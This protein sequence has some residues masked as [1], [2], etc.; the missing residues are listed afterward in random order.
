MA[1]GDEPDAWP[2][3]NVPDYDAFVAGFR[4]EDVAALLSG[5]LATGLNLCVECCDRHVEGDRVA[6]YWEG[7]EGDST[8]HTFAELKDGAARFA[9]VLE[10]HGVGPGDRVAVMLPRIPELMVAAL[11]IWRMGAV[12]VPLFTA[13]GAKAIEYRLERSAARLIVTDGA[14]RAKLDGFAKLPPVMVVTRAPDEAVAAGALHFHDEL[15]AEAPDFAPVPRHADDPFLLMFTSGTV[16]SPK[17]VAVPYKALLS[18]IVYLKYGIGLRPE[19]RFWNMADP[20][21]A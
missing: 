17:G 8:V 13:F 12:Y 9:K 1:S 7:A 2:T 14:N 15:A 16:G 18:F 4:P 3:A 10:T 5:D 20:G 19:D 6:L 21:W 11:G